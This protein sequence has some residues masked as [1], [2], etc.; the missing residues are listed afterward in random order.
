MAL[1]TNPKK[2]VVVGGGIIG[3]ATAF[4]LGE[5]FPDAV[6]TVL[7]KELAVGDRVAVVAAETFEIAQRACELIRVEYELLPAVFDPDEAMGGS[8]PVIHDEPDAI[9]IKDA[10]RNVVARAYAKVGDPVT[11]F[12]ECDYVIER[13]YHVPQQQQASIEPHIV[14]TWWDED[15]RLVIRTSTQ[16]PSG[17][18]M[19]SW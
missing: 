14:M 2:I 9:G 10:Q 4:R 17:N 8:A 6:I 5:T 1:H 3:L 16:V 11:A 12:S 7:E 15:D 13:E 19:A 18:S